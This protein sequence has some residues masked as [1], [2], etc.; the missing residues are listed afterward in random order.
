MLRCVVVLI[1][2]L[3]SLQ[4]SK[5]GLTLVDVERSASRFIEPSYSFHVLAKILAFLML[6]L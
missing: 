2:F 1:C 3:D 5:T 4:M 6:F